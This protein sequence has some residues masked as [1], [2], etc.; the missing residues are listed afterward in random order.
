MARKLI[1]T[2]FPIFI[3]KI[4]LGTAASAQTPNIPAPPIIGAKSYLIIDATTNYEIGSLDPDLKLP[5]A[6][7]TK[8]MTAYV[9]FQAIKNKQIFLEDLVTISEKAW[10]MEGSRMFIEV[11]KKVSVQDLLMGMIVQSGNDASIALAEHVASSEFLFVDLM[12]QSAAQLKMTST[13]FQNA[14]GLPDQ[15]HYSTAYDL[16]LLAK[17]IINE[18]PEYYKWYS[19]KEF[20]YNNITQKNRNSLLWRDPSVDGIK[21]GSTDEAGYCLISSAERNG[22]RLIS[23]VMGTA[24]PKARINGSQAMLNYGFRFFETKKI[25]TA[26]EEIINI[27]TWKTASENLSLGVSDDLKI[28]LPRGSFDKLNKDSDV[29]LQ[30]TGPIKKG[31]SIGEV[32]I[33]LGE[34][35]LAVQPLVALENNPNGTLWQQARDTIQLW[36]E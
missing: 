21:T 13:S 25:F 20:S 11:G 19:T 14:T 3:L 5:P 10:R 7:I 18:F 9:T 17:A 34:K 23:V 16:S 2:L 33:R 27:K 28:T 35:T 30:I 4:I 24:T 6:S 29:P 1:T 12:N 32:A 31:Q 8:L 26:E 22:M 36:F 15:D